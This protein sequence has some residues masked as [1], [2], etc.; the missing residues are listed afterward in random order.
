[1]YTETSA[2][3]V[4]VQRRNGTQSEDIKMKEQDNVGKSPHTR[5]NCKY[6]RIYS[7]QNIE[8]KY[9]MKRNEQKQEIDF[10]HEQAIANK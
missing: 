5:W 2:I 6:R 1:M 8:E 10:P 7:R 9:F 4:E 3:A